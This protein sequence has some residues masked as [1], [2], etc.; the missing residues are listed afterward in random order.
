MELSN[1][2]P[3]HPTREVKKH[4][5]SN[6]KTSTNV[7]LMHA[8]CGET[9]RVIQMCIELCYSPTLAMWLFVV[10]MSVSTWP[11]PQ[12]PWSA[13]YISSLIHTQHRVKYSSV[14]TNYAIST[15]EVPL[16]SIYQTIISNI[17]SPFSVYSEKALIGRFYWLHLHTQ[18]TN[19]T[20][21]S[22]IWKMHIGLIN[23]LWD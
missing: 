20:F 4:I 12:S 22:I 13:I 9:L 15:S 21:L 10:Y 11:C 1:Y 2:M 17:S 19:C 16:I 18:T 6:K 5:N 7:R 3:C 23:W 8:V 14:Y